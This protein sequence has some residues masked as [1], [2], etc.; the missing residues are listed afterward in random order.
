M[1]MCYDGHD[2]HFVKDLSDVLHIIHDICQK[3]NTFST[4]NR[5]ILNVCF[6]KHLT[7]YLF[8]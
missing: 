7:I 1:V 3:V 2:G 8:S 6:T 5:H 4:K